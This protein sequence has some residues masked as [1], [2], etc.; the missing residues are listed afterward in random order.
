VAGLGGVRGTTPGVEERTVFELNHGR[1]HRLQR[2]AAIREDRL[3]NSNG[4]EQSIAIRSLFSRIARSE[5]GNTAM[6]RKSVRRAHR[7][8]A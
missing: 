3:S 1:D 4:F 8:S 5:G 6:Q 2:A 7:F